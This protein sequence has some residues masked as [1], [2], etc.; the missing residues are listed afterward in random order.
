MASKTHHKANQKSS[1]NHH[2]HDLY[3]ISLPGTRLSR[4][5]IWTTGADTNHVLR[6][7][8]PL[9]WAQLDLS[10]SPPG[11]SPVFGPG[12]QNYLL[13]IHWGQPRCKSLTSSHTVGGSD[14]F[15]SPALVRLAIWS[16]SQLVDFSKDPRPP[17]YRTYDKKKQ[18]S[19]CIKSLAVINIFETWTLNRN[20]EP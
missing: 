14:V 9:V 11:S 1:K 20:K 13:W 18:N 10:Y 17:C 6:N 12:R 5:I 15:L 8:D 16:T 3:I 2:R 19:H 7:P 4:S